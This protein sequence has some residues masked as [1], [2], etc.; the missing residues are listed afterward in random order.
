MGRGSEGTTRERV[1]QGQVLYLAGCLFGGC[2]GLDPREGTANLSLAEHGDAYHCCVGLDPSE[3]TARTFG[4]Q[5]YD[6]PPASCVGL[7][8]SEGTASR[9]GLHSW[10]ECCRVA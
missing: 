6:V 1:L 5:N 10:Q 3:G 7:D 4:L 9:V 8:P 2:V